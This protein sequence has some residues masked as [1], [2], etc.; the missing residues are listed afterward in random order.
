MTCFG[1]RGARQD[2]IRPDVAIAG[3]AGR[4]PKEAVQMEQAGLGVSASTNLVPGAREIILRQRK[5]F[6][7]FVPTANIR[8]PC[9]IGIP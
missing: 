7:D 3:V 5:Q 8:D 6:A 9:N 4:E 2:A 1:G